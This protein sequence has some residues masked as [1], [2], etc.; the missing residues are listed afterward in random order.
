[1]NHKIEDH[2]DIGPSTFP[3]RDAGA[4]DI[5]WVSDLAGERS[6]RSRESLDMANLQNSSPLLG[7]VREDAGALHSV[8]DRL[9]DEHVDTGFEQRACDC[10]MLRCG[11][12]DAH[13][14]Y[15]PRKA[16]MV[17][18]GLNAKLGRHRPGPCLIVVDDCD[19]VGARVCCVLFCVKPPE[20]TS[21][22]NGNAD[23][24][25]HGCC[26]RTLR[27]TNSS[28]VCYDREESNLHD[29]RTTDAEVAEQLTIRDAYLVAKEVPTPAA[30]PFIQ[31]SG[32]AS[33]D[34]WPQ[35]RRP[36]GLSTRPAEE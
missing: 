32:L 31:R 8:G 27:S 2:I 34:W 16:T 33:I 35:G 3:R 20:I 21:S 14:V 36:I 29:R 5:E 19:Q 12:R 7:K 24:I 23:E 28:A 17:E 6:E 22:H 26:P 11:Y 25:C 4:L 15:A 9:L 30:R 1:M 18:S 13:G 10:K